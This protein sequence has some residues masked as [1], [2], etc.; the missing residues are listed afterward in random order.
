MTSQNFGFD[1]ALDPFQREAMVALD[2][3]KNVLVTAKTGSGKTLIAE[4]ACRQALANGGR[5][6]YTTPIKSLSN[7]KFQD[8]CQCFPSATVGIVTGDI[9]FR[10]DAD[11][12]IMTTEVL[13]NKLLKA[14]T[15]TQ[16]LG[17]S[18][19]LSLNGVTTLVFDEVH[20]MADPERGH[21]WEDCLVHLEPAIQLV[22]LS[23][24]LEKPERVAQ[25]LTDLKQKPCVVLENQ[26]RVVPLE[27]CVRSPDGSLVV[28]MDASNK[29]HD[30]AYCD[31]LKARREARLKHDVFRQQ[32][33][34]AQR[35][36][37]TLPPTAKKQPVHDFLH[38]MNQCIRDLQAKGMLP[39]LLFSLSRS[40]C[41]RFANKVSTDLLSSTET[42]NV[43]H[44]IDFYLH[45]YEDQLKHL[46]QY[47][48][49]RKLACRGIAYHHSGLLGVLREMVEV[50]FERGFIKVLFCTETFAVGINMPTKTAVFLGLQKFDDRVDRMRMLR[51][52][53][54]LQ[55][56]GRAGR[57]GKDVKGTVL[58]LPSHEPVPAIDL[59]TMMTGKM[60][61]FRSQMKISADF[62]LKML[63]SG[64]PWLDSL[65]RSFF[66][67]EM[68]EERASLLKS[69]PE[70]NLEPK[71]RADLEQKLALTSSYQTADTPAAKKAAQAALE[72]WKN[73]HVG[74]FWTKA[75]KDLL[76]LKDTE[77]IDKQ[78]QTLERDMVWDPMSRIVTVLYETGFIKEL[79]T[80][81]DELTA[82]HL[83]TAGK[84]A[85]EVNEG[86]PV[87]MTLAFLNNAFDCVSTPAELLALLSCFVPSKEPSAMVL[88]HWS[89]NLCDGVR[90]IMSCDADNRTSLRANGL[91]DKTVINTNHVQIAL[92]WM[93]GLSAAEVCSTHGLYAG[94]LY[95]LLQTLRNLVDELH[96]LATIERNVTLLD[97][98]AKVHE[99]LI[100]DLAI[101]DSLYLHMT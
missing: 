45:R 55:M 13:R 8:M 79:P 49:I 42:A 72:S 56:A 66:W 26:H 95:R 46:D 70:V 30:K 62:V 53:E 91:D 35:A 80:N 37:E 54:Y 100:R 50:L 21:V 19:C 98:I 38:D 22:L 14:G 78:L 88:S 9:K 71:V 93:R 52:D 74:P 92:D 16:D 47:H 20:Y 31:W 68:E 69:R 85:T 23:A 60:A 65:K 11:I 61:A 90:Q 58:Y 5:V 48:E 84:L 40:Q 6:F 1:F 12:V 18:A 94:N 4:Y 34:A 25:W 44:I 29:F 96:I 73:K 83:T 97:T 63:H 76:A 27:H 57:R 99:L 10:P 28:V 39:A 64:Q 87:T 101:G 24:T 3:G 77:A 36:G 7:Q 32:V 17:L 81:L 86:D 75:E 43:N 82:D 15:P 2:E 59:K 51:T 33:R 89:E 41:E 67:Q